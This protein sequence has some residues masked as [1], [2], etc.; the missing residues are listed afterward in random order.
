MAVKIIATGSYTP[1]KVLTNQDLEKIVETSDEWIMTRT[2]IRERHIAEPEVPTSDLACEAAKQALAMAGVE[3]EELDILSVASITTDYRF[4][5]TSCILQRKLRTT[6]RC[7]CY[8]VQAACSG[9]LYSLD[10]ATAMLKYR[11]GAKYALVIGAEKISSIVDWSDRST[12]VLFGDAASALLLEKDDSD[13]PDTLLDSI[14]AADGTHAGILSVPAG[15]SAMPC[16]H[17]TLDQHLHFIKMG[18]KEVFKLAVTAMS[19][20]S[21]EL[22]QRNNIPVEKLRWI[23]PHQANKRILDAVG[24]RLNAADGQVY[25]NLDRVG[26]TSAASIGICLDELVRS[27]QIQKGDYVLLTA[28]GAGM[29]WASSLLRWG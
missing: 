26:N 17:D 1:P 9:L 15:G 29:T 12:C 27:G 6:S 16:T 8:D 25:V 2:G 21:E 28:F 14:L 10:I 24:K 7:I 20:A 19:G 18:G 22:L 3:P 23:I 5:S 11:K 4:P 13:E